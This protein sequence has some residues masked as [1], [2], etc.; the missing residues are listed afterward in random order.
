M[1]QL[2]AVF[3]QT[4]LNIDFKS[5]ML[6]LVKY[7]AETQQKSEERFPKLLLE[8]R[9]QNEE[10]LQQQQKNEERLL[11]QQQKKTKKDSK[12]FY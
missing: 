9:Q 12:N 5:A 4:S 1:K 2:K 11:E 7:Q 8:Q 6:E 3:L 10:R